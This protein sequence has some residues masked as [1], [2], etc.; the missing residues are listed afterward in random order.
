MEIDKG[1]MYFKYMIKIVVLLVLLMSLSTSQD[2]QKI[3]DFGLQLQDKTSPTIVQPMG[4]ALESTI[5]PEKY[6]VGPSDVIAVNI[7]MSPPFNFSLTVTPEGTLIIPTVGEVKVSD[8]TL[9]EVKEKVYQ[10]TRKKY[11]SADITVTLLKP[12]PII[13]T[14]TGNVLNEGLYTLVAIDRATRAIEEANKPTRSQNQ[15]QANAVVQGMS[16]RNIILRHR[17]GTIDHVDITK[18]LATKE[19]RWNP[20][21]REGDVIVV[22]RKNPVKNVFGIY[23]EVNSPGRYEFVEGDSLLD[24]F[25]IGMGCTHLAMRDSVEFTRLS[26]DGTILTSKVINVDPIINGAQPNFPLEPGDRIVVKARKELREDY[27]VVVLGEV[28]YP[29]TYPITKNKT[30]IS[31]VV[32]QAGGFTEFASLNSATLNRR[33]IQPREVQTERLLSARGGVSTEDSLDYYLETELRLQKEIVSIDFEKLFLSGDSSQDVILQDEDY[34]LVPSVKKTIYVFG[35][36]VLPGHIAY[37]D[38]MN[39]NYYISKAGGYTDRA[40]KSDVQIIKSKT[41]QWLDPDE[42]TIEEGDYIWIPKDPDRPFSYYMTIASQAAS[43]LSVV[44][45]IMVIVVQVTK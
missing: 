11:L 29:G 10:E 7:W 38:G 4:I 26:L 17:N 22:P 6:F 12:R 15:D 3:D 13:V 45:G 33:S 27:R 34:I 24:A 32:Q 1:V 9:A 35:Q 25:K 41:K 19:D 23:G 31:E 42:T 5:D 37:I 44:V 43:V 36:V 18:F 16:T 20:F 2:K 39:V 40:R 14:V 30:K 28:M 8:I 21:L